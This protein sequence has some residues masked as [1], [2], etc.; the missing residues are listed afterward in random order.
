MI[1]DPIRASYRSLVVFS[2]ISLVC[3]VF[4]EMNESLSVGE[5]SSAPQKKRGKYCAAFDYNN[6]AY[7]INGTLQVIISLSFLFH[8]SWAFS[9][10]RYLKKTFWSL[11]FED[12]FVILSSFCCAFVMFTWQQCCVLS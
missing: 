8:L 11:E 6:S 1:G 7:D 3:R 12:R 4:G 9:G 2:S 5:T 10:R